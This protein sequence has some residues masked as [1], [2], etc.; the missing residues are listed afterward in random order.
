[1]IK[2]EAANVNDVAIDMIDFLD[3]EFTKSQIEKFWL[4]RDYNADDRFKRR[5]LFEAL[6]MINDL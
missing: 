3:R 1:M 2:I 6:K 4:A 5:V